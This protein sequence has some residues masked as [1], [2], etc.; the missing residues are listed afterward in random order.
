MARITL[1]VSKEVVKYKVTKGSRKNKFTF[2]PLKFMSD[3]WSNREPLAQTWH[4]KM[5]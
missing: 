5:R 2:F 1:K 3:L 4:S